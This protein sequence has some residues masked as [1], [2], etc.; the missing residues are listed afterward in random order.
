MAPLVGGEMVI[1]EDEGIHTFTF[2]GYD[3]AGNKISASIKGAADIYDPD[4][5]LITANAPA[6][7]RSSIVKKGPK[8]S[9]DAVS[10][11]LSIHKA[12]SL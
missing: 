6:A 9:P 8:L 12:I 5:N 11:R 3:D 1:T 2:N 4:G 7:T 10:K